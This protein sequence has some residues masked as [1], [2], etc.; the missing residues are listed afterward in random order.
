MTSSISKSLDKFAS[1]F[2][3]DYKPSCQ[4]T[5][6]FQLQSKPFVRA[7]SD[8]PPALA[9]YQIRWVDCDPGVLVT[10][11]FQG[12]FTVNSSNFRDHINTIYTGENKTRKPSFKQFY[13]S[14]PLFCK[15]KIE[16]L[17][18]SKGSRGLVIARSPMHYGIC[19]KHVNKKSQRSLQKAH[20]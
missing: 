5:L 20:P 7:S 9:D 3:I 11:I 15:W 1:E 2:A 19:F 14:P 8:R 10:C 4:V 13:K 18:I 6:S 12:F 16:W 17:A